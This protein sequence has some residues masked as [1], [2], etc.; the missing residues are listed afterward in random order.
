MYVFYYDTWIDA[1]SAKDYLY[2]TFE[3]IENLCWVENNIKPSD[4]IDISEPLD[5]CQHDFIAPTRVKGRNIGKPEFGKF[6]GLKY[7]GEWY[8]MVVP[9]KEYNINGTTGNERLFMS[10]LMGEFDNAIG[11]KDVSKARKIL[12]SLQ[13]DE[14]SANQIIESKI[15]VQNNQSNSK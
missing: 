5:G 15:G 10:G 14:K 6:E 1:P 3:E 12:I 11:A 8:D 13:W 2:S 7:N 9:D 4:W